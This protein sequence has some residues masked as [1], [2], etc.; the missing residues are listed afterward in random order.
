[1]LI[2]S[3]DLIQPTLTARYCYGNVVCPSVCLP[4]CLSVCVVD[5]LVYM[6]GYFENNYTDNYLRVFALRAQNL[7]SSLWGTHISKIWVQ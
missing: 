5:M 2:K 4:V 7:R 6:F 3:I 1:M